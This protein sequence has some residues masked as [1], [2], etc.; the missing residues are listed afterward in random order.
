MVS[1]KENVDLRVGL[2]FPLMTPTRRSARKGKRG[3]VVA[4]IDIILQ[5]ELFIVRRPRVLFP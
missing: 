2:R 3:T 5:E 4:H 1:L